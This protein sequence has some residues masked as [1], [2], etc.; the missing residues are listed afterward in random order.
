MRVKFTDPLRVPVMLIMLVLFMTIPGDIIGSPHHGHYNDIYSMDVTALMGPEDTELVVTL[1]SNDPTNFPVPEELEKFKVKFQRRRHG[2]RHSHGRG[3]LINERHVDLVD[4]QIVRSLTEVPLHARLKVESEFRLGRHKVKLKRTV[5]VTLRPDLIVEDVGYPMT[6]FIDQPF[7][8][9]ANLQEILGENSA[10]ADVT[11]YTDGLT[12]TTPDVF[13]APN[14]PTTVVFT[15]LSYSTPQ[16]IP[17]TIDISNASPAEYDAT[18]N[19]LT[20]IVEV[21]P[22]PTP[23]ETEYSMEYQ[24]W[25]NRIMLSGT[26]GCGIL[27]EVE[28]SGD[29]D[30]FYLEGYSV[31]TTPGGSIDVSFRLYADNVLAYTLDIEDLTSTQTVDDFEFYDYC[32]EA[33]GIFITYARNPG[34]EA[35]FEINKYSGLDI[36][37]NRLNVTITESTIADSGL[38]MD[39][40]TSIQ[41]SV[42]FDDGFA[43][44]GGSASMTLEAPDIVDYGFSFP[45][46]NPECAEEMFF[47]HFI[48]DY[49]YGEGSGTMNPTFLP[50]R[51]QAKAAELHL[52]AS[53]YLAENYPN[54][55]NPTTIIS[56]GLPEDSRVSL[57]LYDISGREVLNLTEGHFSAGRHEL[58]LDASELS[59]GSYFYSLEA[60]SFKQVKRMLLLK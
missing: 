16:L 15:G 41:T 58:V 36:Y 6:V 50:R 42:L 13:I 34:N 48:F 46:F 4:N 40:Q 52:P 18:N 12:M 28:I 20:F 54:P 7:N 32:D 59:S 23:G 29:R 43:L 17:F 2:Q 11:L 33:T 53:I 9:H 57:R 26:E 56:F 10:T 27:E 14:M 19:S 60:G 55:F 51:N 1:S 31:D 30:E 38:H 37:V 47:N 49:I 44:L 35:Y 21:V 25:R 22:P 3:H 39:A 5:E 8:I 24:N 45:T